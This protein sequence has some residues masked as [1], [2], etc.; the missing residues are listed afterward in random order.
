MAARHCLITLNTGRPSS[1]A[2]AA[3]T[4]STGNGSAQA[5]AQNT[6]CAAVVTARTG[7][8]P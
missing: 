2:T 5:V 4:T 1:P 7:R 8:R 3:A 6:A